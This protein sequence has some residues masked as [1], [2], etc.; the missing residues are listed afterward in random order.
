MS[1]GGGG[2]DGIEPDLTP[3]LDLV[4]QLLMFFIVNVN[5]VKEQVS[6]DVQLPIST[7]ARPISKADTGA[8]FINQKSAR[9]KKFVNS[10]SEANRLRLRSADSIILVP[11]KEPMSPGEAKLWLK[12]KYNDARKAADEKGGKVE[13]VIHFR[14]DGDLELNQLF[15]MMDH[16]KT[17]GFKDL[18]IRARVKANR[19]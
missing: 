16:C 13:T 7:S 3:L 9:N 8:I 1:H 17:A 14:P 18:K 12:D 15:L 19:G 5:F 11:G 2:D 4:M 10:L 6:Q